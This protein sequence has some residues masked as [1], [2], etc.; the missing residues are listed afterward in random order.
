MKDVLLEVVETLVVWALSTAGIV[1]IIGIL[2]EAI[3]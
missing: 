1:I 3:R 2:L